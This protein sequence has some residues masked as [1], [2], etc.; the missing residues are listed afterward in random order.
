MPDLDPQRKRIAEDLRRQIALEN[1]LTAP[2]ARAFVRGLQTGWNVPKNLTE[3]GIIEQPHGQLFNTISYGVNTM[4]GYA[5][6]IDAEDRW[7]IVLYLRALQRS[8][9][10]PLS[11]APKGTPLR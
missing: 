3:I 11:D 4:E 5:S 9:V 10:T 8:R 7:A 2:Q 1:E 6:Q